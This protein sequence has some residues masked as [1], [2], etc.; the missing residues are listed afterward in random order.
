MSTWPR[1]RGLLYLR[2]S[3]IGLF[4]KRLVEI[5]ARLL[6]T[7][8]SSMHIS[9]HVSS[10]DP[11]EGVFELTSHCLT[12][13]VALEQERPVPTRPWVPVTDEDRRLDAHAVHL[14]E[15]RGRD[16]GTDRGVTPD[17]IGAEAG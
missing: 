17:R 8:R 6:H 11:R 9:V 5:D 1:A 13:F 4:N 15:L 2:K 3:L 10:A 12:V 16:T 14:M 7:G